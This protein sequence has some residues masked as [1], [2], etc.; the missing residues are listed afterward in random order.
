M[1]ILSQ[2]TTFNQQAEQ[3][4]EWF[5]VPDKAKK[6]YDLTFGLG[7]IAYESTGDLNFD[8]QILDTEN[9]IYN[10]LKSPIVFDT[11]S[12]GSFGL[13]LPESPSA[14][15]QSV[16]ARVRI[17]ALGVNGQGVIVSILAGMDTLTPEK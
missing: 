8:V 4:G 11:T 2:T 16:R 9:Q 12:G 6:F 17:S 13:I 15:I 7:N 1:K 14:I 5:T 3:A 10:I